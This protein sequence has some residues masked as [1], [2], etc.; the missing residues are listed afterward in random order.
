MT[1]GSRILSILKV[2]GLTIYEKYTYKIKTELRNSKNPK[3]PFEPRC[4]SVVEESREDV[5]L[6]PVCLTHL[7]REKPL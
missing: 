5:C 4:Q 2:V 3:L 7:V 6:S 1:R